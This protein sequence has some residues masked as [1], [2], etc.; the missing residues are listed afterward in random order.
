[1]Q[2]INKENKMKKVFGNK[3]FIVSLITVAASL[4]LAA[5][6]PMAAQQTAPTPQPT[7]MAQKGST[8]PLE[9][10]K[11]PADS[12][13][14]PE[15]TQQ[16][17]TLPLD[18]SELPIGQQPPQVAQK[19]TMLPLE[20]D[21]LPANIQQQ[22]AS[23]GVEDDLAAVGGFVPVTGGEVLIKTAKDD[24]LGT[25]LVDGNG[26]TLYLFT[27][28]SPG[29][30]NCSGECLVQW[31]PLVATDVK[32]VQVAAGVNATKLGLA[33]LADGRKIVTY[34]GMP[35]YYWYKD[36]KAGDTTGQ[37]VGKVWFVVSP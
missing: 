32:N 6:A 15:I 22:T 30:S 27:K 8:M 3:V 10:D 26:M 31:P 1:M 13:L 34:N 29:K 28:D 23:L 33:D 16:D 18:L 5:F 4:A 11:V 17:N 20:D 24:K 21:L 12:Q 7:V 25:F 2:V 9:D 37:N 14:P 36:M 19:V 35:L